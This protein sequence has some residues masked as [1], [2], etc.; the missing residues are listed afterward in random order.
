MERPR[1]ARGLPEVG[2][3]HTWE[4]GKVKREEHVCVDVSQGVCRGSD[5]LES[6]AFEV[7]QRN[8]RCQQVGRPL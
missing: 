3:S 5:E 4:M 2:G 6:G 8:Q 7:V 1:Y